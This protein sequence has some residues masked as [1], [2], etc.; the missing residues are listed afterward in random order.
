MS[1][2]IRQLDS[3]NRRAH[4]NR[5]QTSLRYW[6][7]SRQVT[8]YLFTLIYL[9]HCL[10]STQHFYT[11]HVVR[12]LNIWVQT[13]PLRIL[14]K[15]PTCALATTYTLN[16][17]SCMRK[18]DGVLISSAFPNKLPNLTTYLK[19]NT[20]HVNIFISAR[21]RLIFNDIIKSMWWN[22]QEGL[23]LQHR[24]NKSVLQWK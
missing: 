12:P 9:K 21:L 16:V 14:F 24:A 2:T 17:Q 19:S 1:I 13:G 15:T 5:H 3:T 11:R 8:S 20:M 7:Y 4:V 6:N 18:R 10:R 23:V 22:L